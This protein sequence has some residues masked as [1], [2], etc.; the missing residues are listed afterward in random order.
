MADLRA[1]LELDSEGR[2]RSLRL[3]AARVELPG[4]G[5]AVERLDL[6]C[7]TLRLE[8]GAVH[9]ARGELQARLPALGARRAGLTLDF[10]P[11][12][13]R[14]E[15]RLFDPPPQSS[16]LQLEGRWSAGGSW[17]LR[18]R[19]DALPLQAVT[20]MAAGAWLPGW[21]AAGRLE[22]DARLSGAAGAE[23]RSLG[24]ARWQGLAF[25]D[26]QGLRAGEALAGRLSWQA[27]R[28]DGV[29]SAFL[30]A[31]AP[32]GQL[33][34]DPV[35]VDLAAHPLETEGLLRWDP[36]ARVLEGLELVLDQ[37]GLLELRNELGL[38]WPALAP[39]HGRLELRRATL[40]GA[41]AT[42]L[43]PLLAGR[44]GGALTLTGEIS[45]ELTLA[46]GRLQHFQLGLAQVGLAS[47]DAR[48]RLEG[49]SG[50]LHWTADGGLPPP[51]SRLEWSAGRL[52]GLPLGPAAVEASLQGYGFRLTR[53]AALPVLDG[54]VHIQRLAASDLASA[55]RSLLLD[56]ELTPV[57]L[58]DLT[59]ALGW[60]EFGGSVSARLPEL[61]FRDNAVTLGGELSAEAFGGRVSAGRFS[62]R[63][64]LG[65][66]PELEAEVQLRGLDLERLTRTFRFGRITGRLDGD[67]QGLRLVGWQ[68]AAFRAWFATPEN[69]RTR[70]RISQRAVKNLASL[71]GAG[72]GAA[73]SRGLLGLFEEFRYDRI[74]LGC[75]LKEDV[76]LMRGWT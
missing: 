68:P 28:A 44:P 35:F 40:P 26:A 7:P 31:S 1:R 72:A 10:R 25:S 71:G 63:D 29:W 33:Y 27:R 6:N 21:Q 38:D 76:C 67:I 57:S 4:A 73:L 62:L 64:P 19:G 42:Y 43:A 11:A 14:L 30:Q 34:V 12:S 48:H 16:G 22:L 53:P 70:H 9:C 56:A 66:R 61:S 20:A 49:V 47:A 36:G 60:P 54:A 59:R 52:F 65:A 18:L 55:R 32:T 3:Q 5:L 24:E 75:V 8:A 58:A 46:S 23:L 2:P 15:F 51:P 41:Y 74:G 45:G 39:R 17:N 69:D 37:A 50:T 13:R